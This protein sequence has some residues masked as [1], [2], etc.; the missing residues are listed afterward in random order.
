MLGRVS[1]PPAASAILVLA[2][3]G[4]PAAAQRA[5][6]WLRVD[7][8]H[9]VDASGRSVRLVGMGLSPVHSEWSLGGFA[10][11]VGAARSYRAAGCNSM[12]IAVT[13]NHT[14]DQR[15][16]LIRQLGYE[17]FIDQELAPQIGA[18]V[19]QGMYAI[20]DLHF[21]PDEKGL[22]GTTVTQ[23][24]AYLFETIIP[25]WRAI[26][27]RYRDEPRVA[28]FELWNE[29][30]WPGFET[31]EPAQIPLLRGWYRSA[32]RAIREVDRR[33]ILMVSDHNAG[34]GRALEPMWVAGDGSLLPLDSLSPAQILYS[35]HAAA[36]SELLGENA[37][38]DEFSRRHGVPVAYGE[39]EIQP[40][41]DGNRYLPR[42]VQRVLLRS[43]TER[44][45][46]NGLH[47]VWQ[48]WRTGMHDWEDVWAPLVRQGAV[49]QP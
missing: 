17:R 15:T 47:Q 4:T 26:A 32:V 35:H 21:Y 19:G 41:V 5:D 22:P 34:W 7:G 43:I 29:P 24:E 11:L 3:A 16:D 46:T 48:G 14:Y 13:R 20:I 25:L 33:H 27:R 40:D 45:Q 18:V 31:G 6:S 28:I 44:L 12:R 42:S 37:W 36:V 38:V 30:T 9:I 8:A 1:R 49:S 2:V 10:S 39:V 23:R